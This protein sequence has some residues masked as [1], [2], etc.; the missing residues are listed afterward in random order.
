MEINKNFFVYYKEDECCLKIFD[1][2]VNGFQGF[3][4]ESQYEERFNQLVNL[5]ITMKKI[6]VNIYPVNYIMEKLDKYKKYFENLPFFLEELNITIYVPKEWIYNNNNS[7]SIQKKFDLFL[8]QIE[9][10]PLNCTK[11]I[12]YLTI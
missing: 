3:S 1:N 5:P 10:V 2:N 4:T 9:K 7:M 12:T 11:N 6:H 8:C